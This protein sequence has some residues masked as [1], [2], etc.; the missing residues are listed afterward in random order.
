VSGFAPAIADHVTIG[1]LLDMT[2]G[3][4]D[5]ALSRPNSPR[6]IEE[7]MKLI[8]PEPL[9]A[10]P[11][12]GFRYSNDGYI[13]LGAVIQNVTGQTYGTYVRD[14]VLRPAGMTD[15]N[16]SVYTP[17]GV[18]GMAHGYALNGTTL[19]DVSDM[20]QIANP[21]GGASSTAADLLR[22]ARALMHHRL[23]SPAMTT[24]VLTP[25]VNAPQP[26]GPAVDEYTYGF[27]YQQINGVTFVGH[28][29]GTPGYEGQLDIYPASGTVV[30]ILTNQDKTLVPAIQRSETMLTTSQPGR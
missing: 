1:Q 27:S 10:A 25:R 30:V 7:M 8:L 6:T 18:P 29:G 17:A 3:L 19:T 9:Q 12:S 13:V 5:V 16:L 11:G 22:F 20:P 2:S 23:L 4:G 26:G 24:T 15:T 14:H 21:S 28:N